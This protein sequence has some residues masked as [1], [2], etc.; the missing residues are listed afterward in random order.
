MATYEVTSPDGK[1][2]EVTAPEGATQAQVL[3]YAQSQWKPQQP[4]QDQ[5][6][7]DMKGEYGPLDAAMVAAGKSV[8]RIG[9]GLRQ[10]LHTLNGDEQALAALKSEVD[11]EN[12]LYDPL[13]QARPVAT[14]LGEALPSLAV[15]VGG[16]TTAAMALRGGLAAAAPEALSYGTAGERLTRAGVAGAGGVAGSLVGQGLTKLLR[17]AG[18]GAAAVG[19]DALQAAQRVG[20]KVTPGQATQN[21]AMLNFENYLAK[22]PGSAGRMQVINEGNQRALN[23]A[24]AKAMGQQA[25]DL[26][27]GVMGAARADLGAE[28]GRLQNATAPDMAR[29]Q[30]MQALMDIDAANAARGPFASERIHKLVDQGLD[31]AAHG[32]LD[33]KAYKEIHTELANASASAFRSGDATLG[34][35]LKSIRQELDAAAKASLGPS[36]QAA[37]DTVRKQWD[38]FKVL[39]KSNVAEAG[40]VSAPRV[41]SKMR[42]DP[43]FRTGQRSGE[44]ADV[45]RIG[46]AFKS[47]PNPNS[48]NLAQQMLYGNP[49]TGLPSMAINNILARTYLSP[50][51]QR[52]MTQGLVP[53]GEGSRAALSRGGGLLGVPGAF[54]YLG[55]E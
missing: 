25:D 19:D 52:Y 20:Y 35:A 30:F 53:V 50:I 28:F 29:P 26:G 4:K 13:K 55:V 38:A 44:L 3:A 18:T 10:G 47:V 43:R 39:S 9:Q 48:G 11:E 6:A 1:T 34:Q 15:P 41:A 54:G 45:A 49:L 37:W 42:S 22:S 33:G 23:R 2:F 51:G 14:G 27:E 16:A 40:N 5:F 12:R 46:E 36:D 32:Q 31:L 7:R 24:A 21:Q 8:S 17:P